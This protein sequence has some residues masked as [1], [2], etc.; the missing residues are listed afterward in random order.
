MEKAQIEV[1][2][3]K[4][5]PHT[6]KTPNEVNTMGIGK[7]ANTNGEKGTEKEKDKPPHKKAMKVR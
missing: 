7:N 5:R 4:H 1:L 3:E 2:I 6:P